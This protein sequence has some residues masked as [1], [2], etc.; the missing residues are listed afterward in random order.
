[1]I[2][3]PSLDFC[4]VSMGLW[5]INPYFSISRL[6]VVNTQKTLCGNL[7]GGLLLRFSS[8]IINLYIYIYRMGLYIHPGAPKKKRL[9]N[10]P[11]SRQIWYL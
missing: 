11:S 6:L 10:G 1:M 4:N 9:V 3:M 8:F 7:G 5:Y 2:I